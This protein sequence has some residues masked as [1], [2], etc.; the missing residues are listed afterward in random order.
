METQEI[1]QS[2]TI[3]IK[4]GIIGGIASVLYSTIVNI[5]G[6]Q[7]NKFLGWFALVIVIVNLVFAFRTFKNSNDGLMTLK[8][9][10][11]IGA[12]TCVIS[13]LLSV[14]YTYIYTKF[15]DPDYFEVIKEIQQNEL[16]KQGIPDEQIEMTMKIMEKFMTPEL[17]SVTALF[18]GILGG[19]I[20]SV[21]IAAIMKKESTKF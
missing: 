3:A 18:M 17:I 19:L 10:F 15:I 4:F 16:A 21:I 11:G 13:T 6:N 7:G 2:K 5:T 9:G 12:I 8:E 1:N 14:C 20:L